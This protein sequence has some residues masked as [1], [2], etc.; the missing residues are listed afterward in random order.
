MVES[1]P[2]VLTRVVFESARTRDNTMHIVLYR[3][4]DG[5]QP[6]VVCHLEHGLYSGRR[7]HPLLGGVYIA[8][9]CLVVS[10]ESRQESRESKTDSGHALTCAI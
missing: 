8:L 10:L 1:I 9:F 6:C 3:L 4:C 5:Q 7:G 2:N